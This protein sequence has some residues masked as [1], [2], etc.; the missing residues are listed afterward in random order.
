MI[1]RQDELD[2]VQA[3]IRDGGSVMIAGLDKGNP[4]PPGLPL[5]G[6]TGFE[7]VSPPGEGESEWFADLPFPNRPYNTRQ[8][9]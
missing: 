4:N 5:A 8:S 9:Q 3:A 7:P 2:Q 1:G 6:P